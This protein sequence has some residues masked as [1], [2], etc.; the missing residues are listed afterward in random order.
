MDEIQ[1][2]KVFRRFYWTVAGAT[3]LM[4]VIDLFEK[5]IEWLAVASRVPL[6]AAAMLLA[7]AKPEETKTKK[8]LIYFLAALAAVLLV[9][10]AAKWF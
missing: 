10:R 4:L 2:N 5:P 7:T 1:A 8:W 6:I 9:A 3:M